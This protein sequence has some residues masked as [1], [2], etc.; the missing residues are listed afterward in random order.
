MR[1]DDWI[2]GN[3]ERCKVFSEL[4][5][6]SCTMIRCLWNQRAWKPLW[7]YLGYPVLAVFNKTSEICCCLVTQLCLTLCNPMDCNTPGFPVLHHLL[8]VAQTYV[9]WVTDCIQPSH[10]LSFPSI[11]YGEQCQIGDLWRRRFGFG[12]R[13]QAWSLKSFCVAEFYYSEKGQRKLL[14]LTSEGGRRV[15]PSQVLEKGVIYFFNWLLQ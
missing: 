2:F 9:H 13:D 3:G 14:T 12:T 1:Q 15:A 8:E 6:P 5:F 10:P 4:A 11:A 7:T